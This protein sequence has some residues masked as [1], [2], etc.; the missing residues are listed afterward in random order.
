MHEIEDAVTAGVEAGDERG[1]CHGTLRRDGGGQALE[2]ALAAEPVEVGERRPVAFQKAGSMPSM[3]STISFLEFGGTRPAAE[4]AARTAAMSAG[5]L[6]GCEYWLALHPFR[7]G[8]A[9]EIERGWG[10][11]LD[12]GVLRV[13]G[14]IGKKHA[15]DQRRVDGMIAAPRLCD[16][17]R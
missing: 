17:P 6:R 9:E 14:A 10:E 7:C 11:I 8:D 3:P 13:N 15:G 1:P 16:C 2:I 5:V 4:P 12:P